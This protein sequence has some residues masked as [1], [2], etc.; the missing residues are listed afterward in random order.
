MRDDDKPQGIPFCRVCG[1]RENE[2]CPYHT[3]KS[4]C[5]HGVPMVYARS[6][7]VANVAPSEIDAL[8][9]YHCYLGQDECEFPLDGGWQMKRSEHGAWVR[10]EDARKL[11][12]TRLSA[13][14]RNDALEEAAKLCETHDEVSNLA[15]GKRSTQPKT[16]TNIN[17]NGY[18][19]AIRALKRDE[20]VDSANKERT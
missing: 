13:T 4:G 6:S 1:S 10:F 20:Y 15:T 12:D 7:V 3:L 14:G 5:P 8:P 2:P 11:A 19:A 9:R 17:G 18:A 16:S